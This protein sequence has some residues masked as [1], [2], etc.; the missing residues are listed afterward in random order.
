M[1]TSIRRLPA[2]W[3]AHASTIVA[4][5][6]RPSV[7]GQHLDAG[8]EET[9][10]LV[11]AIADFE[12]VI[13]AASPAQERLVRSELGNRASVSVI[14][15]ALDDCWARDISPLFAVEDDR[16]MVAIDFRFNAWGEKFQPHDAD[17]AFGLEITNHL[18]FN[19]VGLDLVLEGGSVSTDGLGTALVVEGTVL[20]SNRNPSS[21]RQSVE[22]ILR[23]E[24]GI[25]CVIWLPYGL[26]GDIDTDGHTDNVAVFC[27]V[28]RV[29]VQVSA[30]RHDPDRERLDANLAIL[31]AARD[32]RGRQ[33]EIVEVPWLPTSRLDD[34]RPCSYVNSYPVHGAV[35]V[36]TVGHSSQDEAMSVVSSAFDGIAP[37]AVESNT[38][39]FG[40]GGPHCMTMQVPR[41]QTPN[42]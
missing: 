14:P 25:D 5:P 9:R 33:L 35:I 41:P 8:R 4:W 30:R 19:R 3:E 31:K 32:A 7:W 1:T 36:P 18:G 28:G 37:V 15:T 27:A 21:T 6:G 10:K 2:E 16:I 38:L 42:H 29:L 40:G 17:D 12:P 39:S 34:S 26:L 11:E 22:A 20:N 24:L 23:S 13:V